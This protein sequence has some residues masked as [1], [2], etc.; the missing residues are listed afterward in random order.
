MSAAA[1]SLPPAKPPLVHHKSSY[2]GEL[3]SCWGHRGASAAYPENTLAS[4]EAAIRD[5]AEG[6]E[7]DVHITEDSEIVMFHDPHLDR[8]T[9]GTGRIQTQKYHGVLDKLVTNK[10]PHQKIPTFRE[11]IALL[12][13]PENM[14]V[15]L[16]IDVKVDNDPE[17]LFALMHEIVSS[18]PDFKTVLAP[19]LVL[20]LWHPKY[21]EP[22]TRL[23][24]Y[25]RLTHIGMSPALARKYF[26]DACGA[27]SMNFSC[28]VGADGESFRKECKA[29]NKDLYVWTVNKRAEMIE[30]T[31]WGAKA[32]LTDRTA[33][34]LKLREQMNED[35]LTVSAETT[36]K[37]QWTSIWYTSLAN[38]LLASWERYVLTQAA[39]E[40]KL[41][42]R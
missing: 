32:I 24:P 13:R 27:F 7:S 14:K 31:K 9:N 18:Y 20:G 38:Y 34:F 4:F 33:E 29:A 40:F 37:F 30:A 23:I 1:V 5:G 22:A 39:G 10:S 3:P 11:T 8:T 25:I 6:I 35:W 16:N 42:G 17:R 21:V 36:W 41:V 26:W 28:L 2:E 12:M 19:R 15:F